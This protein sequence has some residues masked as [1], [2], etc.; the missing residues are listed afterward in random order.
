MMYTDKNGWNCYMFTL[1]SDILPKSHPTMEESIQFKYA[2]FSLFT[3]FKEK[4]GLIQVQDFM[5]YNNDSD[6][7]VKLIG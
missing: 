1:S 3:F 5:I 2:K 7:K 6:V 4:M